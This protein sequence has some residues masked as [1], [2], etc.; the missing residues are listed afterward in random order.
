MTRKAYQPTKQARQQVE[1]MAGLGMTKKDIAKVLKINIRTLESHHREELQMGAI[2]ANM[3]VLNRLFK[4]ATRENASAA[5]VI[6]WTKVRMGW[7]E[8]APDRPLGKK[9]QEEL[10]ALEAEKGTGWAGLLN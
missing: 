7:K 9:E 4:L 10:D 6:Y 3:Q 8:P 5:A 1:T 2:K